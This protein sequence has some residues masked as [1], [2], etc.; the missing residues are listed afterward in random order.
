MD[1]FKILK[2]FRL[3]ELGSLGG[4]SIPTTMLR[5]YIIFTTGVFLYHHP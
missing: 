1:G 2:I 3:Y 5:K 4:G